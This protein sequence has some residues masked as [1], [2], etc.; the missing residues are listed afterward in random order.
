MTS[1]KLSREPQRT[2]D[3]LHF[4][5]K[6]GELSH[7]ELAS[8]LGFFCNNGVSRAGFMSAIGKINLADASP[9]AAD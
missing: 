6:P 5:V 2:E 1:A 8:C 9:S 7:K 3:F 4:G